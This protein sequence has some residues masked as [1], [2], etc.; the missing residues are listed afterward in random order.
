MAE[1][2]ASGSS[3][4]SDVKKMKKELGL[5]KED[6][7][8]IVFDEKEVPPDATRW[9]ALANVHIDKPCSQYW[10]CYEHEGG[11]GSST[12]CEVQVIEG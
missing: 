10:F 3:A 9:M 7:D 11:L 2:G 8:G 4:T 6:L 12:R 1:D 5:S